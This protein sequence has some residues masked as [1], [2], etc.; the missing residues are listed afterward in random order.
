ML[1]GKEAGSEASVGR[2]P[3]QRVSFQECPTG[4]VPQGP[5]GVSGTGRK[6]H[7]WSSFHGDLRKDEKRI[8]FGDMIPLENWEEL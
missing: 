3:R 5:R 2:K 7:I 8:H 1:L 4:L 6:S